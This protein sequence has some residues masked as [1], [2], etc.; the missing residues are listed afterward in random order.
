MHLVTELNGAEGFSLYS[1]LCF[2][3]ADSLQKH[4]LFLLN[5]KFCILLLWHIAAYKSVVF[6]AVQGGGL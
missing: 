1:T 3:S 6:F 2:L 4:V 5:A